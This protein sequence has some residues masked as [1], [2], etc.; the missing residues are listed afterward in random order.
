M[1]V[2]IHG[3]YEIVALET[4]HENTWNPNRQNDEEY[5]AQRESLRVYGQV[6]PLV[7]RNHP[8]KPGEYELIDGAHRTRAIKDEGGDKAALLNLGDVPDRVA[9]KLNAVL[10][11]TRGK[12][13]VL[14]LSALYVNLMEEEGYDRDELKLGLPYT[15]TEFDRLLELDAYDWESEFADAPPPDFDDAGTRRFG[16]FDV[17]ADASPA[18]E[19]AFAYLIR[20]EGL[21]KHRAFEMIV[22][23]WVQGRPEFTEIVAAG[24]N[25]DMR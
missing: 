15:D 2:E 9:K 10:T 5:R 1:A 18:I 20:T 25:G 8:A 21:T 13:D 23:E 3:K 16:P 14:E 22:V 24:G 4:I 19:E 6:A 11:E 12:P 7:C 17:Q